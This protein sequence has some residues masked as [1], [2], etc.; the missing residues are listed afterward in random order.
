MQNSRSRNQYY[1]TR[2]AT[3]GAGICRPLFIMSATIWALLWTISVVSAEPKRIVSI[4]LCTDQF[5]MAVARP[6]QIL[7]LSPFARDREMSHFSD[8][9]NNIPLIRDDA[10]SVIRMKPDLVLASAFSKK[11]TLQLIKRQ[12]IRIVTFKY[13]ANLQEIAEQLHKTGVVTGN[14]DKGA[15][16]RAQFLKYTDQTRGIFNDSDK[17]ALFYQRGGYVSGKF[18]LVGMLL[19]HTGLKNHAEKYRIGTYG[20]LAL[21]LL[22]HNPPDIILMARQYRERADQGYQLLRHPALQKVIHKK[23]VLYFPVSETVCPGPSTLDALLRLKA[24]KDTESS[25]K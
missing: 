2:F 1:S 22:L 9:A 23:R 25:E 6:E 10:E 21:E 4:N 18:S 7:A 12:G 11:T 15:A 13:P 5:L 24:L 16:A 20:S 19:E 17:T 8:K 14:P 3:I